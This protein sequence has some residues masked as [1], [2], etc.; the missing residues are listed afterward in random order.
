MSHLSPVFKL[1]RKYNISDEIV[2]FQQFDRLSF[3]M[4]PIKQ[5]KTDIIQD[6]TSY[7]S[8]NSSYVRLIY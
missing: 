7:G 8:F 2:L 3:S 5:Q 4:E 1:K 6:M